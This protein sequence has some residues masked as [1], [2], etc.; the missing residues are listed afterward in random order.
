[1][2]LQSGCGKAP[3]ETYPVNGQVVSGAARKPAVGAIV[4]C[5]PVD[6]QDEPGVPHGQ[7][8]AAGRFTLTTRT[9]GDGAPAGD[10]IITI[11]WPSPRKS[12]FDAEEVDQLDGAF[13]DSAKSKLRF[14]VQPTATNE[15]PVIELP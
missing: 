3:R 4:Y 1:M 7:V 14:T 9:A 13:A 10:Y 8:D 11:V 5:H 2:I 12:V 15:V 6:K